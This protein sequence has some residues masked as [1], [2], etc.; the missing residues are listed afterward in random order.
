MGRK[1]LLTLVLLVGIAGIAFAAVEV[2]ENGTTINRTEKINFI[3][4][5]VS[6]N[7]TV[8]DIDTGTL[9]GDVNV[10]G[11]LDV[12]DQIYGNSNVYIDGAIYMT[13]AGKGLW[14]TQ[15]DGGCSRCEVAADGTTFACADRTC[16]S[17]M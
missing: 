10:T 8:V 17:G 11:E 6:V 2:R 7:G 1:L 4:P 5:D 9:T 15:A 14:L 13:T 16:P 12:D 3:G